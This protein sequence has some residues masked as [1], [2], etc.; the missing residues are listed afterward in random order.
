MQPSGY[1]VDVIWCRLG[2]IFEIVHRRDLKA[3]SEAYQE[4]L[5]G[6]LLDSLAQEPLPRQLDRV[7]GLFET[8]ESLWVD[9]RSNFMYTEYIAIASDLLN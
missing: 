4:N 5:L 7:F 8:L 9:S 1:D 2:S 3:Y 6:I